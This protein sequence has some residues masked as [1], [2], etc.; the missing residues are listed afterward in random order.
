[1]RRT[2]P[3]LPGSM[4]QEF[5]ALLHPKSL[6]IMAG[7]LV[8]WAGSHAIGA[9]EAIDLVLLGVGVYFLGMAVFDVAENLGDFLILASSAVDENDLDE[10][11][12]HLAKAISIMGVAAFV[13]LLA[14]V[15]RSRVGRKKGSKGG[16]SGGGEGGGGSGKGGGAEIPKTKPNSSPKDP[17]NAADFARYKNELRAA[18]E[19][20]HVE[21]PVLAQYMD[22]LYRPNA[23]IGSGSTAAAVRHEL[24]TGGTVGGRTHSQ[25]AKDMTT[26]LQRWLKNNPKASPGDRAAAE[27]VIQDMSNALNGN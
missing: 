27:N 2:A 1:L 19:K 3:K 4:Q 11:A 22:E 6:A 8:I 5:L 12:S 25:K 17:S 13:A 9:G 21:D 15:A 20:P 26:A 10:A 16:G 24:A 14:K 18:M 7:T 23:Q